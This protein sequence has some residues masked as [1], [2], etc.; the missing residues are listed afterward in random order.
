MTIPCDLLILKMWKWTTHLP[1]I[2]RKTKPR[3]VVE[4]IFIW[5][6]QA[7]RMN[8]RLEFRMKYMRIHSFI[9]ALVNLQIIDGVVKLKILFLSFDINYPKL[10]VLTCVLWPLSKLNDLFT[11]IA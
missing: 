1:H 3:Y 2:A 10:V 4:L 6:D 11:G 9:Y 5:S 8:G 7:Y